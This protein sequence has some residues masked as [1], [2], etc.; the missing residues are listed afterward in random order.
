MHAPSAAGDAHVPK[1]YDAV[2]CGAGG[3]VS[4][5]AATAR[6]GVD[7][8]EGPR[9]GECESRGVVGGGAHIVYANEAVEPA[10]D[11]YLI[12]GTPGGRRRCRGN[13]IDRRGGGPLQIIG[14]GVRVRVVVGR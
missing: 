8:L 5:A 9:I 1:G 3:D 6:D 10:R 12:R 14:R 2:A 7:G 11:E 13:P 4:A